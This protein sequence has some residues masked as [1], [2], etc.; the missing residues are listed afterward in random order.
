ML[1]KDHRLQSGETLRQAI[2]AV[3]A[4]TGGSAAYFLVNCAHPLDIAPA[5]A[6]EGWISRDVVATLYSE[7]A[8]LRPGDRHWLRLLKAQPRKCS[9]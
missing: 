2:E 3:D 5:L 8:D 4:A 1:E 7:P 9:L 6:Q